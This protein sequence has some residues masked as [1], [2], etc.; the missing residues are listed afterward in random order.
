MTKKIPF[1]GIIEAYLHPGIIV[2]YLQWRYTTEIQGVAKHL[3][4]L[5]SESNDG[6]VKILKDNKYN[7]QC[8]LIQHFDAWWNHFIFKNASPV[9][10]PNWRYAHMIPRRSTTCSS[11]LQWKIHYS[12]VIM[13]T[14][15]SQIPSLT[16]FY[17]T[18]YSDADQRRHQSSAS[19]AFVWGIHRGPLNS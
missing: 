16:I 18:V 4:T 10:K 17:S 7:L 2:A 1:S 6:Q 19:L 15:V 12:D 9:R 8:S 3:F 11:R 5:L 13:G 14:I